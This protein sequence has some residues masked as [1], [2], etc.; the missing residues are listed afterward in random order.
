VESMTRGVL[1]LHVVALRDLGIYFLENI[2]MDELV[3]DKVY[4]FLFVGA[5]L[6]LTGATGAS[7]TPLALV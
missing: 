7:M 3:R 6:R 5:P 1:S 2:N 4:E